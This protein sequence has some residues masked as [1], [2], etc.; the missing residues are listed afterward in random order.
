ME[1]CPPASIHLTTTGHFVEVEKPIVVFRTDAGHEAA[2]TCSHFGEGGRQ[3]FS[4]GMHLVTCT[5]FDPSFGDKAIAKCE[6]YVRIK[7]KLKQR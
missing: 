5:A 6:F 2:H 4:L 3:N 7:G 1:K